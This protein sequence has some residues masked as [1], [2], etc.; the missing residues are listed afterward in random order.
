MISIPFSRSFLTFLFRVGNSVAIHFH[1]YL[2]DVMSFVS[3]PF[4]YTNLLMCILFANILFTR[5]R[6]Y[7]SIKMIEEEWS[8]EQRNFQQSNFSRKFFVS[9]RWPKSEAIVAR[10]ILP[11][12]L[13]FSQRRILVER[14]RWTDNKRRK[15]RVPHSDLHIRVMFIYNIFILMHTYILYTYCTHIYRHTVRV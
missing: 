6:R 10:R 11:P 3:L 9:F 2:Y 13:S 14:Y 5:I 7:S 15:F 8:I 1:F 12:Y 4:V